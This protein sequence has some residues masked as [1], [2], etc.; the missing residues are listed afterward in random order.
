MNSD[1]FEVGGDSLAASKLVAELQTQN[2]HVVYAD[3]FK[4]K[5]PAD[6]Y[7]YIFLKNHIIL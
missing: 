2:I 4:Y 1:F 3:I 5:T 6:I 7:K